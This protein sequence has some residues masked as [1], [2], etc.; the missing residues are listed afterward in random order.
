MQER[1][2]PDALLRTQPPAVNARPRAVLLVH[3]FSW[4]LLAGRCQWAAQTSSIMDSL[5]TVPVE[6]QGAWKRR[7]IR[8]RTTAGGALG[9]ECTAPVIYVQTP[10]AFVDVRA[11]HGRPSDPQGGKM[12]AF[13]GVTT[14]E[15]TELQAAH[16]HCCSTNARP[17][18]STYTHTHARARAQLSL[19]LTRCL[20]SVA[21]ANP[22]G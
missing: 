13:G 18:I 12:M 2:P 16:A 20:K 9:P 7:Y 21:S 3:T 17:S 10:L 8:R 1:A 19:T 22:A 4:P 14:A 11:W 5:P 6:L 15:V